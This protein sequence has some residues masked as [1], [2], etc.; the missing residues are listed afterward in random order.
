MKKII[1]FGLFGILFLACAEAER[2]QMVVQ[3]Q[4]IGLKKGVIYLQHVPDSTLITLDSLV[5]KGDGSFRFEVPLEYPELFYLY[6][7]KADNNAINDRISFFGEPGEVSIQTRWD[8]F[9]NKAR[10]Y[11]SSSH[12]VFTEYRDVMSRFNTEY[13][14]L[15]QQRL[16]ITDSARIEILRDSLDRRMEQNTLRSYLY[17]VN[18][19]LN[20]RNSHVAPYLATTEIPDIQTTFLDTIYNALPDSILSGT[21]GQRLKKMVEDRKADQP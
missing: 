8:D 7:D 16:A 18:F 20:N 6:L 1:I 5:I 11:G 3:G 10:I 13:L 17:T 19:A 4:V 15:A 21:Y 2:S 9:V 12:K 14:T